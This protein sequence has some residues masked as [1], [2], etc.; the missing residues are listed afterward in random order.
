MD[1]K[2]KKL[3]DAE[4][5]I[6]K[7]IWNYGATI[8][9]SQVKERLDK[10][11]VLNISAIQTLLNRLIGRGFIKSFKQGK[12]RYYDVLVSENE[13]IT[14]ENKIFLDKLNGSSVTRF[15]TNLYDS[16]AI[17]DDDLK[18]LAAFIEEKTREG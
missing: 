1:K 4:L 2:T 6:M 10:T 17:T 13:Y 8:S 12:N 9:T 5:D 3:P 18:E 15:V 11:R 7:V 14:S 16:N